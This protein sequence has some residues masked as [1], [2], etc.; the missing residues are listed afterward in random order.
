[1][2]I[3]TVALTSSATRKESLVM[4]FRLSKLDNNTNSSEDN[5]TTT[6]T[7]QTSNY[8]KD[9]IIKNDTFGTNTVVTT[10]NGKRTIVTNSLPNHETGVFPNSGNPNTITAVNVTYAM[11][12]SPTKATTTQ[13][14]MVPGVALN[15]IKFEPETAETVTCTDGQKFKIEAVQPLVNLGLDNQNAHV[16]PN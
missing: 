4:L 1:L 10:N 11:T 7:T 6:T 9:Y 5:N 16:Q 8:F 12:L 2:L 15:G 14:A 3:D 13:R